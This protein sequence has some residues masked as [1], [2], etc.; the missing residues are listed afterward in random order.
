MEE[1]NP[2]QQLINDMNE[3]TRLDRGREYNLG[4]LIKD[5][6]PYKEEFID[7]VYDDGTVPGEFMS[8]RG[9]YNCLALDY[10]GANNH[11]PAHVLYE[12]AVRANGHTFEGYKGGDF[13]MDLDTPIYQANYGDCYSVRDNEWVTVKIV[14]VR[15]E[16]DKLVLVTKVEED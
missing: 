3:A 9:L 15:K 13:T 14:G 2:M 10:Y 16:A 5:L 8:W 6:E 1:I 12:M 4:M 7:V 11:T